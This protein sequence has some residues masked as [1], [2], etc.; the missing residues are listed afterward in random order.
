MVYL[1]VDKDGEENL[2]D[3]L[4][5]RNEDGEYWAPID[6]VTI[7]ATMPTGSI[8]SL[9]DKR[10]TWDDEPHPVNDTLGIVKMFLYQ[11]AASNIYEGDSDNYDDYD[12]YDDSDEDIFDVICPMCGEEYECNWS[13]FDIENDRYYYT[14]DCCGTRIRHF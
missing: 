7:N 12:E 6:K 9:I 4:P 2:W 11:K 1:T 8:E 5:V 3:S 10:L 14:C 13:D